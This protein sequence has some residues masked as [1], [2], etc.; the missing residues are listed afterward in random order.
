MVT[1]SIMISPYWTANVSAFYIVAQCAKAA[2]DAAS[3]A[4]SVLNA[5]AHY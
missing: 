5:I 2:A 1:I 3:V 4:L